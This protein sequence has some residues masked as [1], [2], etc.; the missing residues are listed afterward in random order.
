MKCLYND[1][2]KRLGRNV[3]KFRNILKCNLH[4]VVLQ[5]VVLCEVGHPRSAWTH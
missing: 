5:L 1:D 3:G 2:H 4:N